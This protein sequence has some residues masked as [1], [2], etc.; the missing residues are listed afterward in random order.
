MPEILTL[1]L[2]GVV[3]ASFILAPR[4]RTADGFFRGLSDTGAAPGLLTL[5]LSQVTTWIFAR[6]LLN[7]AILGY[8][9]GI[10]GPLAY[11]AYYLSS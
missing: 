10:A 7:A 5:V 2:L 1:A 3:A 8:H 9:F 11:A 4:V 6:S